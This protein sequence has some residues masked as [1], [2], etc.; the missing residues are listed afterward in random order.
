[1]KLKEGSSPTW[2]RNVLGLEDAE[3]VL[4]MPLEDLEEKTA[5]LMGNMGVTETL[6]EGNPARAVFCNRTLNLRS[7]KAIGYGRC[8]F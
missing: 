1:M 3:A 8:S 2:M 6:P 5:E 4:D 7:V